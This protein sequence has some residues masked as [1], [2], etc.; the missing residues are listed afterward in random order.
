MDPP[1]IET[2]PPDTDDIDLVTIDAVLADFGWERRQPTGADVIA[3][4]DAQSGPSRRFPA[5]PVH[6]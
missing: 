4:G 1:P 3:V 6:L 5:V 2:P